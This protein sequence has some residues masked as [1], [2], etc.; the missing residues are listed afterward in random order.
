[1]VNAGELSSR[2]AYPLKQGNCIIKLL[3]QAI[4]ELREIDRP[5]VAFNH[6]AIFREMFTS[7]G[8][9]DQYQSSN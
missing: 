5:V 1:M 9:E 8:E 6:V 3:D 7:D 4:Y 2:I